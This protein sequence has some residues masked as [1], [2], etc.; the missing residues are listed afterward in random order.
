MK[1]TIFDREAFIKQN[2]KDRQ[3]LVE[4]LK[5]S[6]ADGDNERVSMGV[7]RYG[8]A[9]YGPAKFIM[10]T[11]QEPK[12]LVKDTDEAGSVHNYRQIEGDWY[13]HVYK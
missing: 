11:T 4:K 9:G 6:N 5:I 3:S 2:N 12:P 10:W 13:I 7:G 1:E 8:F